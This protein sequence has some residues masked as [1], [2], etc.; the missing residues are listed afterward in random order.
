MFNVSARKH[1]NIVQSYGWD[2]KD[3]YIYFYME[4]CKGGSLEDRL[5]KRIEEIMVVRYFKELL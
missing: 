2:T 5:K 4:Y 3:P 1:P